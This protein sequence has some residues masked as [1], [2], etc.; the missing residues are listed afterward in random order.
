MLLPSLKSLLISVDDIPMGVIRR[1][2]AFLPEVRKQKS[3][4]RDATY[5]DFE[6]SSSLNPGLVTNIKSIIEVSISGC[7][8]LGI[9]KK[10][11]FLK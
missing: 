10:R 8:Q 2:S 1:T 6:I 4:D 11:L 3:E 5:G 7:H 9:S